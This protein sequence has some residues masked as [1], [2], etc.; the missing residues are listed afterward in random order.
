MSYHGHV[1]Q[2]AKGLEWEHVCLVNFFSDISKIKGAAKGLRHM[3]T[4][5]VV[6][7]R[8]VG[9]GHVFDVTTLCITVV[10][11]HVRLLPTHRIIPSTHMPTEN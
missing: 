8:D 11:L 5:E 6:G 1:T 7:G 2:S 10:S 9:E 3:L 4:I